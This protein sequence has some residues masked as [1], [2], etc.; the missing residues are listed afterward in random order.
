M[1]DHPICRYPV[2]D[3]N[4]LPDDVKATILEVQEQS[5]FIPNVFLVLAR[6]PDE[7]RAF[8]MYHNAL[9]AKEGGLSV[10]DKEMIIVAT[11][12]H[13]NCI[14][15]VVAHGAILRIR[16]KNALIADQVATNY[17]KAD[18][19]PRQRAMLDFAIKV[20]ADSAG[21][22]DEDYEVLR[23][24]DFDDEEIWDI[25]SIAG[26]YSLSNRLANFARVRPNDEF[27]LMGRVPPG[28]TVDSGTRVSR[29]YRPDGRYQVTS[30]IAVIL[31]VLIMF[32]SISYFFFLTKPDEDARRNDLLAEYE[33]ASALWDSQRPPRFRYAVDRTCNC[34]P[35]D[36]RSYVA[37]ELDGQRSAAFPIPVESV[38]GELID[39]PPTPLWIED[40]FGIIVRALRSGAVIEARYDQALGYPEF[41]VIGPDEQYEI[42][43][44]ELVPP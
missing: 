27:Y 12:A 25:A 20:S 24:H 10:A 7:F 2:P 14:Y 13:N 42:R 40:I 15:C 3:L 28:Q 43:D 19:T 4:D 8:F 31:L 37:S 5:G 9:M 17:K 11:S 26:L 34:P 39:S 35:E 6:R 21:V 36:D 29:H 16:A 33:A 30:H 23:A 38:S 1:T 41:V 32:V 22:E 18:I 44:F